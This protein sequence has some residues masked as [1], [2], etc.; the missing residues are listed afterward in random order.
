LKSADNPVVI[1]LPELP[2]NA[3]SE[4]KYPIK[5]LLQSHDVEPQAMLIEPFRCVVGIDSGMMEELDSL[6]LFH[7]YLGQQVW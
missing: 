1:A 3:I 5:N 2:G 4:P 6:R 7:R